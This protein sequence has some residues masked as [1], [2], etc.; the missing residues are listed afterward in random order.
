[1]ADEPPS[2]PG[3]RRRRRQPSP[4][5]GTPSDRRPL[6]MAGASDPEV[7]PPP[8][9]S[10]GGGTAMFAAAAT[11]VLLLA[12]LAILAVLA[13]RAERGSFSAWVDDL[14]AEVRASFEEGSETD[15]APASG[16]TTATGATDAATDAGERDALLR[17]GLTLMPTSLDLGEG[18][19]FRDVTPRIPVEAQA[20]ARRGA[21]PCLAALGMTDSNQV[22]ARGLAYYDAGTLGWMCVAFAQR[23]TPP[24]GWR[25]S[26]DPAV[27]F[28]LLGTVVPG[29]DT[30]RLVNVDWPT[31][32][33]E[34]GP[35]LATGRRSGRGILT[36]GEGNIEASMSH[37]TVDDVYGVVVVAT[38][39]P[40]GRTWD[41]RP[42]SGGV[43]EITYIDIAAFIAS[44]EAA[45]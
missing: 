37:W 27:S 14:V 2:L 36:R 12:L 43:S 19:T 42:E 29:S 44:Q 10:E 33:V 28:A 31:F 17:E 38:F 9:I 4:D 21:G 39:V 30:I 18:W 45:R 3:D 41:T 6:G 34:D 11:G 32:D 16:V 15:P 13:L 25:A 5:G 23:D 8:G 20:R 7:S 35:M 40:D 1:M 24:A 26:L 22:V